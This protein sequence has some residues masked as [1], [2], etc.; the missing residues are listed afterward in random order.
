MALM[1]TV[2]SALTFP[3]ALIEKLIFDRKI[4]NSAPNTDPIFIIGHWRSGTTYLQNLLSR[5]PQFGWCDPVSTTTF[6]ISKTLRKPLTKIERKAL[7]TARPMDNMEYKVDLPIEDTFALA[8]IS[9]HSIIHMIAFPVHY[10]NYISGAFVSDLSENDQTKWKKTYSYIINKLSWFYGGKQLMLKSPDNTAHITQL[11]EL[12]PNA[13]FVNIHRDPYTTIMSTIHMFKKQMEIIR[14]SPLPEGDL[15]IILE[16]TI[17]YIFKRM[18]TELFEMEEKLAPNMITVSYDD[19]SANPAACL[20]DIYEGIGLEGY[21]EALPEMEKYIDSQ[22][23]YVKNTFNIKPR[24]LNKI[25]SE[26]GF[27]FTHYGY[28]METED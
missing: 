25:N 4:N 11:L 26:L 23:N 19:L 22:K 21:E 6:S 9:P 7:K 12:Y 20:K 28:R 16:D 17:V 27:Y 5:D 3:I 1:I 10:K 8:T 24:L 2:T 13:R 18:Y 15:D 14:L